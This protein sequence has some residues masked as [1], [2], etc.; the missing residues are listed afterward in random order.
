MCKKCHS[1]TYNIN[2]FDC[3]NDFQGNILVSNNPRQKKARV[4][5]IKPQILEEYNRTC[6]LIAAGSDLI[7]VS[8]AYI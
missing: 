3:D 7:I 4:I 1:Y 6:G 8:C 2:K 5:H